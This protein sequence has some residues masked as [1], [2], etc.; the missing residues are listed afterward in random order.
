V[1]SEFLLENPLVAALGRSISWFLIL[2][3]VA[4]LLLQIVLVEFL[5]LF[6]LFRGGTIIESIGAVINN[7][8]VRILQVLVVDGLVGIEEHQG[9]LVALQEIALGEIKDASTVNE[10]KEP[11]LVVNL[12]FFDPCKELSV[13]RYRI[14]LILDIL[15]L[16]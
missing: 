2:I 15:A 16:E 4:F 10:Y 3:L 12:G 1:L 9:G 13:S 7:L 8:D 14:D 6:N 5:K 11:D